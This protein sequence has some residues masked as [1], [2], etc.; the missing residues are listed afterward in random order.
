MVEAFALVG[1]FMEGQCSRCEGG[2]VSL[3]F[4]YNLGNLWKFLRQDEM[5]SGFGS[6]KVLG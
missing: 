5:N 4:F 3:M 1:P 6:E 2:Q